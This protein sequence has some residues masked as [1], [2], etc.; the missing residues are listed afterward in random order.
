MLQQH[1]VT[2][3]FLKGNTMSRAE[4]NPLCR[5]VF[6]LKRA[7]SECFTPEAIQGVARRLLDLCHDPDSKVALQAIDLLL[8]RLYGKPS[9]EV[10]LQVSQTSLPNLAALTDEDLHQLQGILA[11]T[12][13]TEP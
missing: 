3:H 6:N 13:T 4:T 8:Q 11:R 2:G 10:A 9:Q 12:E 7:F 1:P 5:Q